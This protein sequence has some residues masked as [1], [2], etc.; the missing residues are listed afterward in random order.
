MYHICERIFT[1]HIRKRFRTASH[2][3]RDPKKNF[4][5]VR[6]KSGSRSRR[7]LH[8]TLDETLKNHQRPQ[9]IRNIHVTPV[10][11]RNQYLVPSPYKL[12]NV[13]HFNHFYFVIF[14]IFFAIDFAFPNWTILDSQKRY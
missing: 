1:S 5:R 2:E 3:I 7:T 9:K 6:V 14:Q 4:L 11:K 12:Y 13:K 10:I 8:I